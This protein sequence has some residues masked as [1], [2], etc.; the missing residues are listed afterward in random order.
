MA[1][2]RAFLAV[3]AVV[4]GGGVLSIGFGRQLI[5][6]GGG[7]KLSPEVVEKLG[8]ASARFTKEPAGPPVGAMEAVR[9]AAEAKKYA[10][11]FFWKEQGEE[12]AAMRKVFDAAMQKAADRA[13]PVVVRVD[14][15]GEKQIV[16]KYDL[17]RAPMPLVLAIAPNGAVMGGFPK[18]CSED[19]LLG[20]FGTRSIEGCMKA[21]QDG[22]LVFLCVQNASTSSNDEA[23]AGVRQFQADGR[24]AD[25]TQVVT[26][27]PA[28]AAEATLL[29]DLKIDP[30]TPDAVT[31]FLAP[32]GAAVAK[33]RGATNKEMF[34]SALEKA[35]SGCAPGQACA[36]GACGPKK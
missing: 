33:L 28:D 17:L 11:A 5:G 19:E 29:T 2:W 8:P 9:Q 20:A 16:E 14:D 25:V 31:V 32:P 24:F 30:K 10:F 18:R 12:T 15:P 7:D 34:V 21:L 1:R 35:S 3:G 27:D 13:R 36:P 26:L 4:V 6:S 22:K 23:M